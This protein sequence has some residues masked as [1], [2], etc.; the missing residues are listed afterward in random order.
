[1]VVIIIGILKSSYLREADQAPYWWK[2]VYG[3]WYPGRESFSPARNFGWFGKSVYGGLKHYFP[4]VDAFEVIVNR[5]RNSNANRYLDFQPERPPNDSYEIS[6]YNHVDLGTEF[7]TNT[8]V[9]GV[10]F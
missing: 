10:P 5:K 2:T 7:D 9:P 6:I 4:D 8:P 3:G 1:M